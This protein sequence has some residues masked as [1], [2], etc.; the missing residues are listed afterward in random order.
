MAVQKC[1]QNLNGTHRSFVDR[2]ERFG[3][4][5]IIIKW[6]GGERDT[7]FFVC[8]QVAS[9]QLMAASDDCNLS[10][11]DL[12]ARIKLVPHHIRLPEP[13]GRNGNEGLKQNKTERHDGDVL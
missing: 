2:M 12:F 11:T 3:G 6:K 4:W 9:F 8:D 5:L 13:K 7:P 10:L 1:F